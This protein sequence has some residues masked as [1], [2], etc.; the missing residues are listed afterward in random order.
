MMNPSPSTPPGHANGGGTRQ[1]QRIG[2]DMPYRDDP[3]RTV[4][5]NASLHFV[6]KIV[7][8]SCWHRAW[9]IKIKNEDGWRCFAI[10]ALQINIYIAAVTGSTQID[11]DI[12][13]VLENICD[14]ISMPWG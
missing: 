8:H 6:S 5:R 13:D 7:R 10:A 9:K 2:G 11:M 14:D 3:V 12:R 4:Y 1:R